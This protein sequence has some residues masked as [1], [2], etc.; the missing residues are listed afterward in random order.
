MKGIPM[1]QNLLKSCL[2]LTALTLGAVSGCA[3]SVMKHDYPLTTNATDEIQN[4]D[5]E[6]SA[7][8][9]RQAHVLSPSHFSD[10]QKKLSDAKEG[11]QKGSPNADVLEDLGYAKAHLDM[12]NS[13]VAK[14]ETSIPE[15]IKARADAVAANAHRSRQD[16]MKDADKN[17]KKITSEF[18]KGKYLVTAEKKAELLKGYMDLE[19][20]SIKAAHLDESK[21]LIEMAKDMDAGKLAKRTL[22]SAESKYLAAERVIDADRYDRMKITKAA[23]EARVEAQ[24][25][26]RVTQLAAS[27]KEGTPES[28]ALEIDSRR[29]AAEIARL[30]AERKQQQLSAARTEIG[31]STAKIRSLSEKLTHEERMNEAF[32]TAQATF[33][34]DEA[35]VYRQGDNL[36]LRLKG[37]GFKPGQADVPAR[38][39]P[40]LSKVKDIMDSMGAEKVVVEG[41]TDATGG[42]A[43]NTKL[44]ESRAQAIATYLVSSKTVSGDQI[45]TKGYGFE[46]P[47]STN[48]TRIGRAQNRRV[49]LVISPEKTKTAVVPSEE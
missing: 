22:N 15:V 14:A 23:D 2:V 49:D 46:K 5:E 4:L 34:K 11:I 30:D 1:N 35:E 37:M 7:A 28:V 21:S 38:S 25:L 16:D 6:M 26:V 19:L 33:S 31:T 18:E 47:V 39:L 13:V 8:I 45:E 24:R 20:A 40:V 10:A 27:A 32:K 42:K 44:S 43:L 17:L 29:S 41:H 3:S 36:L 9:K 48:K 12:A